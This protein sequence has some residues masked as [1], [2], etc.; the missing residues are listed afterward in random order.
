MAL[1]N[2]TVMH[3]PSDSWIPHFLITLRAKH[4][5]AHEITVAVFGVPI[6]LLS[7]PRTEVIWENKGVTLDCL[8]LDSVFGEPKLSW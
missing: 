1:Y 4:H 7:S 2:T 8:V 5:T 3:N 6:W